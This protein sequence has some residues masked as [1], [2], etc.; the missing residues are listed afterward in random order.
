MNLST[1]EWNLLLAT[2]VAIL[3]G[4]TWMLGETKLAEWETLTQARREL[5][6]Q[7]RRSEGQIGRR[8]DLLRSMDTVKLVLPQHEVNRDLKSEFLQNIQSLATKSALNIRSMEPD[9]EKGVGGSGLFKMAINVSWTGGLK[10]LVPFLFD[11]QTQ[12]VLMDVRQLSVKSDPTGQLKGS[13]V[14]DFAYSRGDRAPVPATA[15]VSPGA[16]L[17]PTNAVLA[18]DAPAPASTNAVHLLG[19]VRPAGITTNAPASPT[20]PGLVTNTVARAVASTNA[21]PRAGFPS[22]PSG[23][24]IRPRP[25]LPPSARPT[26]P[27]SL[28]GPAAPVAPPTVLPPAN[29]AG[30]DAR[31]DARQIL[32][33]TTL[34][35]PTLAPLPSITQSFQIA[36]SGLPLA[37]VIGDIEARTGRKLQAGV[38]VPPGVSLTVASAPGEF[39]TADEYMICVEECLRRQGFTLVAE[40]KDRFSLAARPAA[41]TENPALVPTP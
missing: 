4:S 19:G 22:F 2:V 13:F 37:H 40:G 26:T 38:E 39:L 12:G 32:K 35:A 9:K 15:L 36:F 17:A 11:L 34:R 41:P 7:R 29:P 30:L 25:A 24:A 21:P 23:G 8:S 6:I 14:V 27:A 18:A 16:V 31:V 1:R 33:A 5:D 28:G 10:E 20:P 3:V